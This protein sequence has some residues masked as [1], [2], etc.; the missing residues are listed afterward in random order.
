MNRYTPDHSS[1]YFFTPLKETTTELAQSPCT[2]PSTTY[3]V[4]SSVIYKNC[5]KPR[6]QIVQI[7]DLLAKATEGEVG[8]YT[9]TSKISR[10]DNVK[11]SPKQGYSRANETGG[12]SRLPKGSLCMRMRDELGPIFEDETLAQVYP[13]AGQPAESPASWRW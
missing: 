11:A 1:S 4:A 10:R 5:T 9:L 13:S 12:P 8:W 7:F 3:P 6:L 2:A